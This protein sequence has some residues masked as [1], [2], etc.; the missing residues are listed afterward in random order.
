MKQTLSTGYSY[1]QILWLLFVV[2]LAV[3]VIFTAMPIRSFAIQP[4]KAQQVAI[5]PLDD[6]FPVAESHNA[7]I[8]YGD[9][10]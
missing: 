9:S 3:M 2:M 1:Q 8:V 6:T 5:A 10:R 4:G 7:I